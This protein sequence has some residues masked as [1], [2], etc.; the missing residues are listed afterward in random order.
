MPGRTRSTADSDLV[1]VAF[2]RRHDVT[3][4]DPAADL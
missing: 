4:R 2:G 3:V 1:K